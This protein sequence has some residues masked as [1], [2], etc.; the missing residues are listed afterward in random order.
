MMV[1]VGGWDIMSNVGG[2]IL[3]QRQMRLGF[4]EKIVEHESRNE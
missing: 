3:R 1:G 4:I 2:I